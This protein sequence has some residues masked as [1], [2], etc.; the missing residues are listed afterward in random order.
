MHGV[1][2]AVL[3]HVA[4]IQ[5]H[6]VYEEQVFPRQAVP[7]QDRLDNLAL[8]HRELEVLAPEDEL[9]P[10]ELGH[11]PQGLL[12]DGSLV[13]GHHPQPR[14]LGELL[15]E[16][17]QELQPLSAAEDPPPLG[18]GAHRSPAALLGGENPIEVEND[19][20]V[21]VDDAARAQ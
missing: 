21:I 2:F 4:H 13:A 20:A 10:E 12:D 17:L 19:H 7:L 5:E 18:R 9:R 1:H 3:G 14:R 11:G 6:V 16:D 15:Q 8:G